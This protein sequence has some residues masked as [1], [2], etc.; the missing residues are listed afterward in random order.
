M[1]EESSP[2]DNL[3]ADNTLRETPVDDR[4]APSRIAVDTL[5]VPADRVPASITGTEGLNSEQLQQ[6]R[7]IFN[8]ND[9]LIDQ[10]NHWL[11]VMLDSARDPM[12]WF[13][14]L[15]ASLFG[16]VGHLNEALIL[17]LAIIPLLGINVYLHRRTAASSAGLSRRMASTAK[18][19]RDGQWHVIP[20]REL[21]P[22]DLTEVASGEY[23]PADG[24]LVEGDALQSDES[25]LTGESLPVSKQVVKLDS[26]NS[27]LPKTI[28]LSCWGFAGTRLLTGTA[29][30]RVIE[31]GARTRYGAIVRSATEA[32]H[33]TTPLQRSIGQMVMILLGITM[34]VCALLAAIRVWQGYGWLDA[35]LSAVTLAVAAIPEEFPVVYTFFLGAGVY[36]LAQHKALVRRAVAVENIGRTS[37]IVSDK[38]GTIT[39]GTLVL[40]AQISDASLSDPL[41]PSVAISNSDGDLHSPLEIAAC[42]ARA[43]SGDPLDQILHQSTTTLPATKVWAVFPFTEA[44]RRE[45]FIRATADGLLA[46]YTKGAPETILELCNLSE[47]ERTQWLAKVQEHARSGHKVIASAWCELPALV[48]SREDPNPE[49]L[50]EPNQGFQFAG[51][52]AF[53]DPVRDGVKEAVAQCKAAGM[54]IIMV[55]GDHPAT[56]TAIARS[57]GLS[58]EASHTVT[59]TPS[60]DPALVLGRSAGVEVVARATPAQ[61]LALVKVLQSQG[62]LVAVTGDGVNDV[63]ALRQADIGIAMGA[64]GTQSAREVAQVVLLDDNFKTIVHAIMQGHDLFR[65][66]RLAF[67]Y[68]LLVHIPLVTSASVIPFLGLPLLL[69]PIHVVWLELVIHPTAIL[70]FQ[71]PS[72]ATRLPMVTHQRAVS[73]YKRSTWLIIVAIGSLATGGVLGGYLSAMNGHEQV[74]HA[75]SVAIAILIASSAGFTIGLTHLHSTA[76]KVV[77]AGTLLS[78]LLVNQIP[79]L[80]NALSLEP[81]H[82]IDW[83]LVVLALVITTVLSSR[84]ANTLTRE[85]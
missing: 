36:R 79:L 70:A 12:L 77:V 52:L 74:V 1:S 42:A 65:N 73:F 51:L 23:F 69:L 84:L 14:V 22:G 67:A 80:G 63:P 6:Q 39:A 30:L 7:N 44:R 19:C 85:P 75:R 13:L 68:L 34:V 62:E 37:C 10:T 45:T 18:V 17:G 16:I 59:M 83:V 78:L 15:S 72:S 8:D 58:Q 60:D 47:G 50:Q 40:A 38:T 66:L 57:I 26:S 48:P 71:M 32:G 24:V 28:E 11:A 35:L 61:K 29:K 21:V 31:T 64:R 20:S 82:D 49:E 41:N 43:D 53:E 3:R 27:T 76:S 46:A 81:L 33:V 55:T 5:V 25:T 2:S 4:S 56:A 54:R 9:I